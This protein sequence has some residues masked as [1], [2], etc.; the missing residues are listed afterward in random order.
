[1]FKKITYLL[2]LI[3]GIFLVFKL[4][5]KDSKQ[6]TFVDTKEERIKER[7]KIQP[8]VDSKKLNSRQKDILK[9]MN[10]RE[11]LLPSDIYTLHPNVSTR[12]LRRDMTSLV[13]LNLVKQEGSTRDTKYILNR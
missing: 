2:S 7:K 10:K 13:G 8:K 3:L 12:T 11:V 6:L 1:M 9:L 4:V 5:R